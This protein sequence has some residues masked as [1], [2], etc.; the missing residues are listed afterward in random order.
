[1]TSVTAK[2]PL[3]IIDAEL[4]DLRVRAVPS[5]ESGTVVEYISSDNSLITCKDYNHD[6]W[7]NYFLTSLNSSIHLSHLNYNLTLRKMMC[8][9]PRR[10]LQKYF[11]ETIQSLKDVKYFLDACKKLQKCTM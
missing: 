10:C 1:M 2:I 6:T 7:D 8:K 9:K 3:Q 11:R 4:Q 5:N